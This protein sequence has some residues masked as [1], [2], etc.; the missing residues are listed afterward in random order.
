MTFPDQSSADQQTSRRHLNTEIDLSDLLAQAA[1]RRQ[2]KETKK[3]ERKERRKWNKQGAARPIEGYPQA[4]EE[5][6]S[7]E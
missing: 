5:T 4:D 2:D 6:R 1:L 7:V 3:Q